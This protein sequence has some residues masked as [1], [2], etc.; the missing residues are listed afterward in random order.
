[1]AEPALE[2]GALE[3]PDGKRYCSPCVRMLRQSTT[4]SDEAAPSTAPVILAPDRPKPKIVLP[5]APEPE[6]FPL[7]DLDPED[8]PLEEDAPQEEI[9]VAP[10]RNAKPET[11]DTAAGSP[12]APAGAPARSSRRIKASGSKRKKS[13]RRRPSDRNKPD[14]KRR[15]ADK[16]AARNSSARVK[17]GRRRSTARELPEDSG[18]SRRTS[19]RS[20]LSPLPWYFKL[21]RG[22]WI[23]IAVGGATFL[24]FLMACA[25]W[26]SSGP[27][28]RPTKV[29]RPV[30]Y[31]SGGDAL[32]SEGIRLELEGHKH[33]ALAVYRRAVEA[34]NR[35]AEAARRNG[36]ESAARAADNVGQ[37]ANMRLY[38]IMKHST[39][40]GY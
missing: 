40:R 27:S 36:D 24:I 4:A 39:L 22:Q 5:T 13:R 31:G 7:E 12:Q 25:I 21:N 26:A 33:E 11:V 6:S 23:G 14:S 37:Q 32:L 10:L 34:S 9:E 3:T 28:K 15:A 38:A 17:P 29:R 8:F 1:V 16:P 2:R 19:R 30:P 35:R 18:T 20:A